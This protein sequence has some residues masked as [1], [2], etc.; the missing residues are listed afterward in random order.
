MTVVPV[1]LDPKTRV[2]CHC[3]LRDE[4]IDLFVCTQEL[5]DAIEEL[6]KDRVQ[7]YM[8]A[9][10][11]AVVC[12]IIYIEILVTKN[13]DYTQTQIPTNV[14]SMLTRLRQIALHPGLVPSDY[15][16]QLRD[17]GDDD[18]SR[19][20]VQLSAQ[21][22]LRLQ[23]VLAQ[24]IEDNEECPICFGILDDPRITTCAHMFCLAW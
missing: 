5:Y 12:I 11:G 2:N 19:P 7:S 20:I 6:S 3:I 9:H 21:D 10:G 22:K 15:L 1:Q 18:A 8:A 17:A 24:G 13:T 16:Q 23:G 14:L 4:G